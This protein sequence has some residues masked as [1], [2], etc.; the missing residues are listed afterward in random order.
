MSIDRPALETAAASTVYDW[1]TRKPA[2]LFQTPP[3]SALLGR[4]ISTML[5]GATAGE[6]SAVAGEYFAVRPSRK[7][8]PWLITGF[9]IALILHLGCMFALGLGYRN[10]SE[11]VYA[12]TARLLLNGHSLY[13]NVVAAQPPPLFIFGA[14]VLAIHDSIF[15]LRFV[16]GLL[17]VIAALIVGVI[18][19]KLTGKRWAILVAVV[20][21]MLGPWSVHEHG[22][23]TPEILGIPLILAGTLFAASKRCT[24]L[25]G[26]ALGLAAFTKLPFIIFAVFIV[27]VAANRIKAA[28]W[29]IATFLLALLGSSL[30]FGF[31]NL[32]RDIVVAQ[33]QVGLHPIVGTMQMW[34]YGLF[35]LVVPFVGLAMALVW[36]RRF[37]A[38]EPALTRT[39]FAAGFA[40][41]IVG[42]STIKKGTGLNVVGPIE[43]TLI[44]PLTA[45]VVV[46]IVNLQARY[47]DSR[48]FS[49]ALA[50]TPSFTAIALSGLFVF[51]GLSVLRDKPKMSDSQ[52]RGMIA[53]INACPQGAPVGLPPYLAFVSNRPV[54]A[55]QPDGFI[56]RDAPIFAPIRRTT[57]QIRSCKP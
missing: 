3:T 43:A 27:F 41:L 45:V 2:K 53:R 10:N 32:W 6:Y 23:I 39:T 5:R 25:A 55:D 19:W 51:Q 16:F 30:L 24:P 12:L 4:N 8:A 36:R 7:L 48:G 44:A 17:Q 11:G 57:Q 20:L 15:F 9:V 28:C 35:T 22:F 54:P 56:T 14:G 21:S 18:A 13:S 37:Y 50:A 34:G 42:L 49:K 26:F 40:G 1:R 31:T 29:T 38:R 33:I 52:V 47:R 46:L